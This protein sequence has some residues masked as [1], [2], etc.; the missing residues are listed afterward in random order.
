MA[1]LCVYEVTRVRHPRHPPR[2]ARPR[3][4]L[5]TDRAQITPHFEHLIQR[6]GGEGVW[7]KTP[8]GIA[9]H[10]REVQSLDIFALPPAYE[11]V[12]RAVRAETRRENLGMAIKSCATE[13]EGVR[14][15]SQIAIEVRR[16]PV[17]WFELQEVLRITQVAIVID[18]LGH[19]RAAGRELAGMGAPLTFSVM[20]RLP[21]SREVAE[22]AHHAGCEVMLHLPMQ[23]LLD[24]APD[25]SQDE[26]RV[27][28][29]PAQVT[30]I[31]TS[32]L[33]SVP[34]VAGVN[35]HMG[36]R[37]TG[38]ALL[39]ASVMRALAARH[40]F[41]IDSLTTPRSV[42]LRLAR[43]YQVASFYRSVFLDDTRTVAYTLAQLRRLCQIADRRGSALAIGHPYPTTLKAL[44]QFLPELQREGVELVPASR[45]AVLPT[46]SA[47]GDVPE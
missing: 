41:F 43:Q 24:S 1:L 37:A 12:L 21:Y 6:A 16:E 27:G 33:A 44:A 38:D 47:R 40:L 22:E 14:A 36:S 46:A 26:L 23:P 32:D 7:I 11:R 10:N 18:D 2:R 28:M 39:M 17:F 3:A 30:G 8:P 25:V 9:A 29:A 42:A 15:C 45:L 35:N 31:I 34:F 5:L 4:P 20:P 13:G 19:N